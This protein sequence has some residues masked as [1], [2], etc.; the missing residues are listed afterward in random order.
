[1]SNSIQTAV[2]FIQAV[3]GPLRI[4]RALALLLA[5]T[6]CV[7]ISDQ[8]DAGPWLRREFAGLFFEGDRLSS[9]NGLHILGDRRR[10]ARPHRAIEHADILH[11]ARRHPGAPQAT[12]HGVLWNGPQSLYSAM[13]PGAAW[14]SL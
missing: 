1:M 14:A 3:R 5:G 4:P 8:D 7:F 6:L 13:M 2:A 12:E 11:C 10:L 9:D